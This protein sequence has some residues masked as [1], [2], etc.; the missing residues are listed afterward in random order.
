MALAGVYMSSYT[1]A[2]VTKGSISFA[3]KLCIALAFCGFQKSMWFLLDSFFFL[4]IF[5]QLVIHLRCTCKCHRNISIG[6]EVA[7]QKF[8][9]LIWVCTIFNSANTFVKV[10][11][12]KSIFFCRLYKRE[13]LLYLSVC[14]PGQI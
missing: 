6:A 12:N 13:Q 4:A 14:F 3:L 8:F 7:L 9:K 1:F 10:N 5:Q 2:L 11:V